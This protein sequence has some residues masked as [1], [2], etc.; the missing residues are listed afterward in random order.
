MTVQR[1]ARIVVLAGGGS[2]RMGNDKITAD[3]GGSTVLNV[4]LSGLPP[5]VDVVIVGPRR[6]TS[7]T[8][9]WRVES[10]AGGGPVAGVVAGLASSADGDVVAVVAGDLPF[11]GPAL[12]PLLAALY[13]AGGRADAAIGVD[14]A[15]ADQ[16][17]LAAY[18]VGP[19]RRAVGDDHAGRSVRSV[20]SLLTVV[21]V[22]LAATWCLDVDTAA[23][24][25]SARA[26]VGLGP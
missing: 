3:L 25:A 17:L 19:L 6:T 21:R 2:K 22:P 20:L 23:D 10:P 16:P 13:A 15:G 1:P 14:P 12:E 7:R 8:V 9:S 11:A 5:E 24:L 4:L 18:R 26:L